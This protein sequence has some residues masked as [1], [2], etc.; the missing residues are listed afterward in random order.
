M[1]KVFEKNYVIYDKIND[2]VICFSSDKDIVIYGCKVEAE[3]DRQGNEE[4][5]ECVNLPKHQ[6]QR[7]IRQIKN[8]I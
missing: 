6:K 1:S 7:L 2:H 4:V 8:N 5:I 3:M